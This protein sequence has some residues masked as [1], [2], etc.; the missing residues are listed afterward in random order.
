V[1]VQGWGVA[2]GQKERESAG[3]DSISAT[4]ECA[5]HN[6]IPVGKL[7]F[8]AKKHADNAAQQGRGVH[9][10]LARCIVDFF[11]GSYILD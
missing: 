9:S 2:T 7:G 10:L 11:T 3:E 5:A 8:K 6:A 1:L 4:Q